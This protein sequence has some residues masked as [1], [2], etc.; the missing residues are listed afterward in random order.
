MVLSFWAQPGGDQRSLV[1]K[2]QDLRGEPRASA[3]GIAAARSSERPG[4]VDWSSSTN[5]VLARTVF[6]NDLSEAN[7][8]AN[9]EVARWLERT[10]FRI[11]DK[12]EWSGT[13]ELYR[14]LKDRSRGRPS[15]IMKELFGVKLEANRFRCSLDPSSIQFRAGDR[16]TVAAILDALAES[17]NYDAA[18]CRSL[19][20]TLDDHLDD[21]DTKNS[22]A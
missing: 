21:S 16:K 22:K 11:A 17:P 13:R 5:D 3:S 15:A 2:H 14:R 4:V 20:A 10:V 18:S 6:K 12:A 7:R 9:A 19:L 1:A 8:K